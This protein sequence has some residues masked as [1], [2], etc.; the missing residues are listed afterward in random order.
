MTNNGEMFAFSKRPNK[1]WDELQDH[2]INIFKTFLAT[3]NN[4]NCMLIAFMSI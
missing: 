2:L 3:V 1:M 4:Y